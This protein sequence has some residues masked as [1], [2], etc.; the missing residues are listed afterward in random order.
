VAELE[1]VDVDGDGIPDAFERSDVD[2]P[3][4]H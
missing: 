2:D 4:R 1:S 3:R